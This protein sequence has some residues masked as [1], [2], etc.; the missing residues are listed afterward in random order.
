MNFYWNSHSILNLF[1]DF[2]ILIGYI[3]IFNHNFKKNNLNL[4][5]NFFSKDYL[6]TF[7]KSFFLV[8]FFELLASILFG[9]SSFFV[10]HFLWTS[11]TVFLP[12]FLFIHLVRNKKY[13]LFS[14]IIPIL[15]LKFYA[16]KIEPNNLEVEKIKIQS[17]KIKN[18]IRITHISDLQT[19]DIREFHFQVKKYSDEFNPHLILFT[20]DVQNHISIKKEVENYLS[21]FKKIHSAYFVS[22]NVDGI[23]D[24]NQFTKNIDYEFLDEKVKILG[25]DTNQLGLVGIGIKNYKNK[26]LISE[27]SEEI[28]NSDFKILMT[29]HPDLI[30]H[31]QNPKRIDLVL[32]GHTHGGQV[33]LPFTGPI[34]TLSNVPKKIAKGGLNEF[35]GMKIILS[36]GLGLEGHI[37]PRVRFLSRPHLILIEIVPK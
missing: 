11:G 2:F 29:H 25:I 36:R 1:I 3:L 26:K 18:T 33:C 34:I 32:A 21:S 13:F 20:G 9:L 19:D 14:L 27:L 37:A 6:F 5:G 35:E 17:E 7:S 16:E 15:F 31:V 24:L 28:S 10:A 8:L 22:G 23:L 30:L 12:I 4:F